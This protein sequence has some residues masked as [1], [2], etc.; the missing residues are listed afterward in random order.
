[1]GVLTL[2]SDLISVQALKGLGGTA[3]STGETVT[4]GAITLVLGLAYFAAIF[5][6]LSRRF[7]RQ[8]DV[9]GC[10]AV[11]CG[12]PYCPPHPDLYSR[13]DPSRIEGPLCPVG[14]RTFVNALKRVAALNR[15]EPEAR[16]WRHGSINR[17][18]EFL[19]GLEGKPQAERRF[20]IGVS[21]LRVGLALALIAGL[22][23][24]F[25][26]G[27]IDHLGP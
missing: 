16:S 1:M 12:N 23:V 9:F 18:I 21:W 10:R 2:A 20:Q 11:S 25:K 3:G 7:E 19:E 8:A 4:Q 17:R 27:A 13:P 15:M 5:G 22:F 6:I 24:A 14:I 26:T